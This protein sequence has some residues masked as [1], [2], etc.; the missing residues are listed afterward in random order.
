MSPHSGYQIG[1][2]ALF[3]EIGESASLQETVDFLSTG[4]GVDVNSFD[5][6]GNKTIE[7]LHHEITGKDVVLRKHLVT[8]R[9]IRCAQSAKL[10]IKNPEEKHHLLEVS[11]EYP[12]GNVVQI[13]KKDDP[14]RTWYS[15]S[16]TRKR[17]ELAIM[18]AIRGVQEELGIGIFDISE[19]TPIGHLE[20]PDFHKSSAY[21]GLW[22]LVY[23]RWFEWNTW[24][25]SIQEEL[26]KIPDN[27]VVI[28]RQWFPD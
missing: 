8:R 6:L 1:D 18:G 23:N 22:S 4:D 16:E 27:G 21:P 11:R 19:L 3:Q 20:I 25:L 14:F 28:N 24:Q 13:Y 9:I 7:G 5:E 2:A 10:I 12:N 26:P 17:G 15:L